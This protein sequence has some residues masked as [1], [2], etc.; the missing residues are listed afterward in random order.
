MSEREKPESEAAREPEEERERRQTGNLAA[1]KHPV[2][3]FLKGR[4]DG[5]H[6]DDQDEKDGSSE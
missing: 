6:G 3:L 5:R 4:N 2:P 1:D